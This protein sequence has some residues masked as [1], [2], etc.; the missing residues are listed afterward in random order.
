MQRVMSR[1]QWEQ[2]IRFLHKCRR[3]GSRHDA[4]R[5]GGGGAGRHRSAR[6]R[7]GSACGRRTATWR[8]CKE[9]MR[10]FR[11]SEPTWKSNTRVL[12]SCARTRKRSKPC[13]CKRWRGRLRSGDGGTGELGGA[14]NLC[15]DTFDV[16]RRQTTDGKR[17]AV[18]GAEGA[19]KYVIILALVSGHCCSPAACR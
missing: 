6:R 15:S 16:Y 18:S 1:A 14:T 4:R 2:G 5:V 13:C 19:M 11:K 8:S 9:H 3:A 17:L 7:R 12:S 10:L